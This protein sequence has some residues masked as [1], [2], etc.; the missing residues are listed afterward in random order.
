MAQ[1]SATAVMLREIP[2]FHKLSDP[3]LDALAPLFQIEN[4]RRGE[5]PAG[6]GF[7]NAEQ[8]H[9]RVYFVYRGVVALFTVT[10][11]NTRKILFFLG[12]GKLLN[13]NVFDTKPGNLYPEAMTDTMLL[14]IPKERFG[15]LISASP[16]LSAALFAHYET[17]LWRM[18]H[19]LKNTAGYLSV[20]RTL[21]IKLLK[22]SQDH[23]IPC[24]EGTAIAFPLTVTQTA[25]FVGLPR[26]TTSRACKKLAE[27]GLIR[28]E[29][30]R[31]VLCDRTGL[32]SY[33]REGTV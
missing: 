3:E 11:Q 17:D 30:R 7:Q 10:R 21:A 13:H 28:Y 31:F 6:R 26:E 5:L 25:E 2:F 14:S 15:K 18:S 9:G 24:E 4:L 1:L 20:E 29:N 32:V 19:Q 33:Y 16:T 22:L 8:Y 27:M 12:A 23:G